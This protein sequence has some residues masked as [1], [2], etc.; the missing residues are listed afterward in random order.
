MKYR[1][2]EL[3]DI[4]TGVYAKQSDDGEVTY[5]SAKDINENGFIDCKHTIP[6]I[7]GDELKAHHLLQK[8]DVLFSSRG[9][10]IAVHYFGEFEKAVPSN[11]FLHLRIKNKNLVLPSYLFWYLNHSTTQ[12]Y[13]Q[14]SVANS[15]TRM[16]YINKR[17]L[18]EIEVTVPSIATQEVIAKLNQLLIKESE[19]SDEIL[20]KKELLYQQLMY[21]S[22][23]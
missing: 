21:K 10:F 13:I 23:Y 16:P 3:V 6:S 7:K 1:L 22:I 8:D 15:G 9:S 18:G 11:S 12:N 20:A 5:I 14:Q 2:K 4:S 17:K 19:L